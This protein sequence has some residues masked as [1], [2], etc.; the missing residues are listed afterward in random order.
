MRV[1]VLLEGVKCIVVLNLNNE[2]KLFKKEFQKRN[3]L[4]KNTSALNLFQDV[5]HD[6]ADVFF[7]K[8]RG[9]KR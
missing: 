4:S 6:L 3:L 8:T 1:F 9:K 5:S 2:K 7:T